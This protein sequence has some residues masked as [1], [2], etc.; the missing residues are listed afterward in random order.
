[1]PYYR[2]TRINVDSSK[3]DAF[4]AFYE[5][6]KPQLQGIRGFLSGNIIRTNNPEDD[7]TIGFLRRQGNPDE[8]QILAIDQYDSRASADAAVE[9]IRS[10]ILPAMAAFTTGEPLIREGESLWGLY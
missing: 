1:M 9:Q 3:V 5:D 7:N 4:I 2:L 6:V 8:D 10:I